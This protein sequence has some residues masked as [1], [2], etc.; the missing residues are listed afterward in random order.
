MIPVQTIV[1]RCKF[2]LDAEG[3][4]RY[5]F[6]QDFK[7]AI[8][9]SIEWLVAVFNKVFADKKLSEENLR[10][11]VRTKIFLASQFSRVNLDKDTVTDSIW[12]VLRVVPNPEVYPR[13]GQM[14]DGCID[15][16][17]EALGGCDKKSKVLEDLIY[18]RGQHSCKRLTLE[19]WEENQR[20][21][22]EAGNTIIKG[23]LIS[24]A[25]LNLGD[26]SNARYSSGRE[27]EIRPDVSGKLIAVTYLKYP[28]SIE[29]IDDVLPFPES[30]IN[31][32]YHKALN[33]ISFKQGDQTN[34]YS[35]TA[36]DI[37]TLVELMS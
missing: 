14:T 18:V 5:L 22:F 9:S 20:N 17:I 31:L 32:I 29:S 7:P 11:L 30:M 21:V 10:E 12:S 34:L 26:Y 4:D 3:S 23:S 15:E 33:F 19:E 37:S 24:F 36:R 2:A 25:Y 1:D 16:M 13:Q 28:E 8:N 35:V 27:I 6:D